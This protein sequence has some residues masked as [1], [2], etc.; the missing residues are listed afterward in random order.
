MFLPLLLNDPIAMQA[1]AR[2]EALRAQKAQAE[3]QY[4]ELEQALAMLQRQIDAMHGGIQE[5]AALVGEVPPD[6][7]G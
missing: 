4:A 7:Q 1:A 3:A 2:L 6:S 5:L